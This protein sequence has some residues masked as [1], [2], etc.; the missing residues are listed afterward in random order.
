MG[1]PLWKKAQ[2]F[3]PLCEFQS[4][5]ST[6]FL[7]H[8]YYGHVCGVCYCGLRFVD[9]AQFLQHINDEGGFLPHFLLCYLEPGNA[10][11]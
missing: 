5:S 10:Q 9:Y 3:C 4:I 11:S 7:R 6:A 8:V 1:K 2:H